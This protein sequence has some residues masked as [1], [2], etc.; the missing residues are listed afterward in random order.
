MVTRQGGLS[1][2]GHLLCVT[3]GGT[4]GFALSPCREVFSWTSALCKGSEEQGSGRKGAQAT[5]S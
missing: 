5:F 4:F 3:N 1:S 2:N